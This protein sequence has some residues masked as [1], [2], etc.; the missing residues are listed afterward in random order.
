MLL[1]EVHLNSTPTQGVQ[2][3]MCQRLYVT[4]KGDDTRNTKPTFMKN[5]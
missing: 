3:L 4:D 1:I 2:Y 5:L